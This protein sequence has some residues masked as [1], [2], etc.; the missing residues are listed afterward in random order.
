MKISKLYIAIFSFITALLLTGCTKSNHSEK[1]SSLVEKYVEYWNTGEFAGIEEVLHPG[2]ELRMTP[3]FIPEK[4]IDAFKESIIKWRS[5]YP[6]FHI[7][8]EEL[9]Y[10][11]D[12]VA[13][14]WTIS[15][16]NTGVGTHPPTGKHIEVRGMSI[17]HFEGGKIRD[18]WIA[19]NSLFWMTQL[20]FKLIPPKTDSNK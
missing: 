12:K 7:D 18:E 16:T 6:D 8:I 13:A 1:L 17:I 5:A 15:A 11:S 2:F 10:D 14:L 9:I 19:S 4:G 3:E 20:G